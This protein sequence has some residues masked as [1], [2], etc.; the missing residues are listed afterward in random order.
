MAKG[1]ELS[2]GKSWKTQLAA[3]QHFKEMLARYDDGETITDPEDHFDLGALLERYDLLLSEGPSKTGKGI[4][5]FEKRK[6]FVNGYPTRG[7]WVYRVDGTDTDFSYISAIT[8]S[9]KPKMQE[10]YDACHN[11]VSKDLRRAKEKQFDSF[12][13]ENGCIV[14][15]I[16]GELVSFMNARLN[17]AYPAF[18]T[19]VNDYKELR[20]WSDVVPEGLL[21]V[22]AD[23]QISTSFAKIEDAE[24]FRTF[25]N[26]VAVLRIVAAGPQAGTVD[27]PNEIQRPIR[28][29]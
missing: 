5:R 14:C 29:R 3:K 25:H 8:G 2:N 24:A 17:H 22:S 15:E 28:L 6:S 21:T 26:S 18:I 7:F 9:A 23:R 19:I 16:S 11:A 27:S 4:D 12:S 20:G 1:V 13:D 10:F